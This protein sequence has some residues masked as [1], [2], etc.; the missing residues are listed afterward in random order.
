MACGHMASSL[1]RVQDS[2]PR[3]LTGAAFI[4]IKS[5]LLEHWLLYLKFMRRIYMVL[6]MD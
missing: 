2:T 3:P 1:L 6:S 5:S 4:P